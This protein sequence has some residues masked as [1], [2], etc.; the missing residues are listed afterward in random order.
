MRMLRDP[1]VQYVIFGAGLVVLLAILAWRVFSGGHLPSPEQLARQA[2]EAPDAQDRETAAVRLAELANRNEV[3]RSWRQEAKQQL[4]RVLAKSPSPPVRA[5][6]ILGLAS[7][8]DY[9][10]MPALLEALD[11]RSALVRGR[12]AMAVRR[13]L[14]VNFGY[15]H[16]DPPEK[17]RQAKK[18]ICDH[19]E[20]MCDS[21]LMQ[22]W[23]KR[24]QEQG[25]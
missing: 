14:S 9:Q 20:T 10:S 18:R 15:H 4:R 6:C 24:L 8:W 1:K 12:A 2:L 13:L 3:D 5:A 19:W 17:R 22:T 7:Q 21:P 25:S 16:D 23:N 11:D